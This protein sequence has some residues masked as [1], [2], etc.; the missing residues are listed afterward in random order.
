M[1]LQGFV[2][3]LSF[4]CYEHNKWSTTTTIQSSAFI[5]LG[6]PLWP[7]TN[8]DEDGMGQEIGSDKLQPQVQRWRIAVLQLWSDG[9]LQLV[10]QQRSDN[11][12]PRM[13]ERTGA[14]AEW[15]LDDALRLW[16]DWRPQTEATTFSDAVMQMDMFNYKL[17]TL[18]LFFQ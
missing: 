3:S 6:D 7:T 4:S 1:S 5:L 15:Q 8:G 10:V 11:E 9:G 16:L 12:V 18:I 17:W 2:F 14:T 13:E